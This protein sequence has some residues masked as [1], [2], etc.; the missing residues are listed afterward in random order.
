MTRERE[1]KKEVKDN[2]A[3]NA[4]IVGAAAVMGTTSRMKRKIMANGVKR[5]QAIKPLHGE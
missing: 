4:P 3:I 2:M 1:E 5:Q